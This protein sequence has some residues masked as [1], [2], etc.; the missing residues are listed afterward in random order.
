MGGIPVSDIDPFSVFSGKAAVDQIS[1]VGNAVTLTAGVKSGSAKWYK[2][3][4][5]ITSG[6]PIRHPALHCNTGRI[7]DCQKHWSP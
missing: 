2:D 3:G 6:R 5:A 4:K 1:S 7:P